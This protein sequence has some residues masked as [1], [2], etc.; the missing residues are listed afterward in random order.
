MPEEVENNMRR[1][2]E[3]E[4]TARPDPESGQ[5]T[6]N[7]PE[8]PRVTGVSSLTR[9]WSLGRKVYYTAVPCFLA[10]LVTFSASITGP[11]TLVLMEEFNISR[12][13]ALLP[14]TLY[15]V[16]LALGPMFIASLSELIGRRWL[17]I[18]STAALVVFSAGAGASHTYSGLLVCR[19]LAGF[20]GT[21]GIAMGA[22]T[23]L[24][25]WGYTKARGLAA[26]LFTCGPFF[27][28]SMGPLAGAYIMA[29]YDNNWRWTQWVICLLGG[30]LFLLVLPMRET[31]AVAG[32]HRQVDV[33]GNK[34]SI[35][36]L[37]FSILKAAVVR[38]T[39][40]LTTEAI[41]FSLT[42]Y[43][44]Y[45][46]AVVF[47]FFASGSYVYQLDYGFD[48]RQ[49]GLVFLAVVVGY[50]LA[51]ILHVIVDQ[52]L[53][54]RAARLAP[55]GRAAPEHRLYSGMAGSIFLPIGLFWY[56]WASQPG[57]HWAAVAAS[58]VPFGLGAFVLFLSSIVYLV[59]SYGSSS[60]A[61]ALAANGLIRYML[62][63][64][65][66][67]FTFQMYETLGIHW[68][69]SLFALL[70]LAL[71]PIPWLLFKH[72]HKLRARSCF[73]LAVKD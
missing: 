43:T 71:L 24:D 41:C 7:N 63:A 25:V 60:A 31:S 37:A 14:G 27:G 21:S 51:A 15:L 39:T 18:A 3:S 22:G 61:S 30:P 33:D 44:G 62:G 55:D 59:E 32:A 42:L 56:A 45:A 29:E 5:Q 35:A 64:V 57:G 13:V 4:A 68:A 23:I 17:Y 53:Y 65:F 12:T 52:T 20:F 10:Y 49:V 16:G 48:E 34:S 40:M 28:P 66:P 70:S 72:G 46:Y 11:S 8:K 36:V 2:S 67:L 26:L 73:A 1:P 47:S 69:G 54:A 50:I 58:G 19:F 38:S 6:E 9:D